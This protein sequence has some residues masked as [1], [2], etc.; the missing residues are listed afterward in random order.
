MDAGVP[1]QAEK[2]DVFRGV[3][4]K[5]NTIILACEWY[6]RPFFSLP[7]QMSPC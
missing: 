3:E 2:D 1:H 4:I 5:K 6:G 7:T